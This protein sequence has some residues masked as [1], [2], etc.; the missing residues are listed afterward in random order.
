M[1]GIN[2]RFL[3]FNTQDLDPSNTN[4]RANGRQLR[5]LSVFTGILLFCIFRSLFRI[6]L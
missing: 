5:C 4:N 1:S 6:D 2:G 3:W